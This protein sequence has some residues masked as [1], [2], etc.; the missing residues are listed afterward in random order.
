MITVEGLY[1]KIGSYLDQMDTKG[2]D[3]DTWVCQGWLALSKCLSGRHIDL[4][5]FS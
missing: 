1:V 2:K 5:G 4:T 3:G